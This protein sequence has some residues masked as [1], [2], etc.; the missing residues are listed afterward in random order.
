MTT[1]SELPLVGPRVVLRDWIENDLDALRHWMSPGHAWQRLDGPYYRRPDERERDELITQLGRRIATGDFPSP[2]TRLIIADRTSNAL[3]GSVARYWISEETHWLALGI[4][5]FDDATWGRGL[6]AEAL[7]LWCDHLWRTMPELVRLDL[8][9]WS[10]NHGMQALARKLG[11]IEEAR[12]RMARIVDG[13]YHDGLGFGILR[14][15]W[16]QRYPHGLPPR[17]PRDAT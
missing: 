2:R 7:W 5:L 1:A 9:T 6:G 12:F 4:Q 16:E 15:E 13:T 3:V 14:T 17:T 8:R 10:G 11:F